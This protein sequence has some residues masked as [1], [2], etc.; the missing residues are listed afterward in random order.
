[1]FIMSFADRDKFEKCAYLL[2]VNGLTDIEPFYLVFVASFCHFDFYLD[3]MCVGICQSY[4]VER[5]GLFVWG[6][7]Q[8]TFI[9]VFYLLRDT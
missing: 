3:I 5:T 2:L 1:M 8:I 9:G 6:C 7:G 4:Y